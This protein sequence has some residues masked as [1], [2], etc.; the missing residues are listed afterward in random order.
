MKTDPR[1]C[2]KAKRDTVGL[3]VI[4]PCFNEEGNI[5]SLVRRTLAVFDAMGLKAELVLIDDGSSDATWARIV[6]HCRCDSRVCGHRHAR[7]RGIVPSWT[8]GLNRSS[9]ELVCLID[10]DLQNRPEDI[11]RLY[12]AFD[13]ET[14][15]VVQAVRHAVQGTR[16][17]NLFSMGL[18]LLL[19]TVF[20]MRLR[21][22]KSGFILCRRETLTAM[23]RHRH[24]YRYFQ[25][26]IGVSA[27]LRG[28]TIKEVD[29]LFEARVQGRSFLSRFPLLVSC[30]IV[31]EIIKFRVETWALCSSRPGDQP[32]WRVPQVQAKTA[33]SEV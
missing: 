21:D 4:A 5:G 19:N 27:G 23:L 33:S 29:T 13:E 20:N 3:S 24:S 10:A 18:L 16:R 12:E 32:C 22:S 7:N 11:A 15:D 14:C 17:L 30:R 9:G 8:T 26:L 28:F 6:E 25:S 1:R 2:A 31:W